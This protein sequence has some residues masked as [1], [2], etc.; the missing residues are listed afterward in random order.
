MAGLEVFDFGGQAGELGL[1]FGEAVGFGF[2]VGEG[3]AD[4]V[5]LGAAVVGLLAGLGEGLLFV[6][7]L[8]RRF[9]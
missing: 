4:F 6:G 7:E 8:P 2:Q 9:G 3:L 1:G 5:E